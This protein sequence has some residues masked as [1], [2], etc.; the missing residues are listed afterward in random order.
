KGLTGHAETLEIQY[1]DTV[2]SLPKILDLYFDII[3][4]VSVNQQGEDI[5]I[6]YRTGIYY[7]EKIDFEIIQSK[8]NEIQKKYDLPLAVEVEPI[9]N[10]FNAE[11]YHQKYLDKNPGAYCHI[12]ASKFKK[13]L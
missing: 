7:V 5:G 1:D 12:P 11:E 8:Y 10:F 9:K 4:P 13:G 2:I 6:S 3:D